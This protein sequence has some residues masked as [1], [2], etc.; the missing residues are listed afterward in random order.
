MTYK[1]LGTITDGDIRRSIWA[2]VNLDNQIQK[3]NE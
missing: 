3:N 2:K 1:T